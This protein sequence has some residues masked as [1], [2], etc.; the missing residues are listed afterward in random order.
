MNIP[1][2]DPWFVDNLAQIAEMEV[3]LEEFELHSIPDDL[4]QGGETVRLLR[5]R[6][7]AN[8]GR[9]TRHPVRSH[10]SAR[11]ID[12]VFK[13]V[14]TC[15]AEFEAYTPY[16]YS[17]YE[18][19]DEVRES[20]KDK[21]M[22]L[23]S[24]PNRIGQGIEFDYCCVHA[25]FACREMGY[26]TIMVN[27]NPET[28]ST[29]YDTSDRLYFEPLTFE[30]VMNIVDREK[31]DGGD[32][33]ARGADASE[34]CDTAR[35]A[36]GSGSW[37]PRRI[38]S[39]GRRTARRFGNLLKKLGIPHPQTVQLHPSTVR[40]RSGDG[41]G[42]PVLVRPSYV[43]GGRAMEIVYSD[44]M[45]EKYIASAVKASPEHPILIDKFLED[46][47][48]IDVDALSDGDDVVVGAV[49]EHVEEA[50]IH[51]GDSACVIPPHTLAAETVKTIE[52]YTRRLALELGVVGLI[53]IQYAVK[54]DVVYVLEVNPRAS[55]TV[56]FVS[57][58]H[59]GSPCEGGYAHNDGAAS[60]PSSTSRGSA[61]SSTS[62]SRKRCFRSNASREWTRSSGLR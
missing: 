62:R 2:I 21:V 39:T 38:L 59:R 23:G 8:T 42:Y 24:G 25:S 58:I 51:S 30:D 19:E 26:E 37:G 46:A 28:V 35:A 56:P 32:R 18:T 20:E 3:E 53:N 12:A 15:A 48:E 7:R 31:P 4:L 16:Y 60:S 9:R 49:M 45:M 57:K 29:D 47:I 17:T 33:A 44:E 34:A 40:L 61:V 5:R 27:C 10:R 54:D 6:A 1:G 36:R 43:L 22:I 50:G 11:G 55:R 14:D 41:I 13:S 52:E